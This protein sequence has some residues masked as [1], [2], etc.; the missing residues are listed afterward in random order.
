MSNLASKIWQFAI[1]VT[2][3]VLIVTNPGNSQYQTYASQKSLAYIRSELCDSLTKNSDL[4][5]RNPCYSLI[6]TAT[7]QI[8]MAIARST[9][10]QNFFLFS[11]YRTK[12]TISPLD[13][14]YHL[15]TLGILN[16]F[17]TYQAE[18]N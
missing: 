4:K 2:V 3:I 8:E 5:L 1:A 18:T 13:L 14:E 10:Q 15:V 12:L 6:D 16:R 7:P 9:K 11:I 17:Y